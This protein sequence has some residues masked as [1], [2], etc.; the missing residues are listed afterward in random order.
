MFSRS[1]G[2]FLLEMCINS[3]A[4]LARFELVRFSI[5]FVAGA[6]VELL[7]LLLLLLLFF[8]V[9]KFD[10]R[11]GGSWPL[12]AATFPSLTRW[13]GAASATGGN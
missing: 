11:E 2:F 12:S 8:V 3:P 4:C 5:H 10:C 7:S 13:P 9:D 1:L 6:A